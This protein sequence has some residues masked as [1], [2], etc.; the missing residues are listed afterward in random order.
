MSW[1]FFPCSVANVPTLAGGLIDVCG[2][3]GTPGSA[4]IFIQ[5]M[6]TTGAVGGNTFGTPENPV[7]SGPDSITDGTNVYI[8]Y[9][10]NYPR[11]WLFYWPISSISS[12]VGNV[13]GSLWNINGLCLTTGGDTAVAT[14][15]D[16]SNI[17]AAQ[18]LS[19]P[20]SATNYTNY[21]AYTGQLG[22]CVFDGTSVWSVLVGTDDLFQIDPSTLAET[23]YTLPSTVTFPAQIGFDG[24]YLYIGTSAGVIVWDTT[25]NTGAIFGTTGPTHC[26]Y[27]H[28]L[29]LVLLGENVAG[30]ANFYTMTRGGAA[31]VAIGNAPAI[32]SESAPVYAN[33][34]CDGPGGN[35]LWVNVGA[36]G[37]GQTW[38]LRYRPSG[39]NPQRLLV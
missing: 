21:P 3:A 22:N 11:N 32:V 23:V 13:V 2:F 24:R 30:G 29:G 18:A 7:S 38:N 34:F 14:G 12:P 27:S 4:I 6:T 39:G 15:G 36:G 31:P 20:A 28:N 35:D 1:S 8:F 37:S 33:G 9:R 5:T 16:N 26:Y 19:L 17:P 25:T 10:S